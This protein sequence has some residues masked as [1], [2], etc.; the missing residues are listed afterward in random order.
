[1][2]LEDK[3]RQAWRF[4]GDEEAWLAAMS[5]GSVLNVPCGLSALGNIR[6]DLQEF[7]DIRA[8]ILNLPLREKSVDTAII[9][10]PFK[11]YSDWKKMYRIL[12]Q[13]SLIARQRI[14]LVGTNFFLPFLRQWWPI[15]Y[16]KRYLRSLAR[17]Y[18][19][20]YRIND[21]L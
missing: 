4:R 9:D 12:H 7:A 16:W 10:V 13:I 1:M 11:W 8:D 20:Y 2:K 19:V 5:V 18:L 15:L 21:Q 6:I 17:F 3:F 14:I